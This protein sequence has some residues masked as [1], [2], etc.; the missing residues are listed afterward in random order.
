MTRNNTLRSPRPP[1][2]PTPTQAF[3]EVLG[4]LISPTGD[5]DGV[6][7]VQQALKALHTSD[8]PGPLQQIAPRLSDF[9][10]D[11]LEDG[12]DL[13]LEDLDILIQTARTLEG[14][15]GESEPPAEDV[16]AVGRECRRRLEGRRRSSGLLVREHRNKLWIVVPTLQTVEDTARVLED[17]PQLTKESENREW[18]IDMGSCEHLPLSVLST[19]A[20]LQRDRRLW[21]SL[22]GLRLHGISAPLIALLGRHFD[23]G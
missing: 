5:G 21:I 9:L 2:A 10:A 11:L 13:S 23:V 14:I 20:Q 1:Q 12:M 22:V 4:G 7:K 18:V 3:S 16:H 17:L 19:L 15:P 8:S 6:N